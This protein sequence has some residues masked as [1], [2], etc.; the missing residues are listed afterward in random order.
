MWPKDTFGVI[1]QNIEKHKGLIDREVSVQEIKESRKARDENFKRNQEER[2]TGEL[3]W[4]EGT[5]LPHDYGALLKEVQMRQF[6]ET[7]KWIF[8]DPLFRSWLNAG[9]NEAKQRLLWLTGT[10]GAGNS[11]VIVDCATTEHYI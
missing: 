5:I 4:L 1:K 2:Y 7:G 11:F 3:D 9:S 10:P 8:S 6:A